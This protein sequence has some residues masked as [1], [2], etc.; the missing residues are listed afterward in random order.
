MRLTLLASAVVMFTVGIVFFEIGQTDTIYLETGLFGFI[1]GGLNLLLAIFTRAGG[2]VQ[3]PLNRQDPVKLFVDK[4]AMGA[5]IYSM[6]FSDNRLVL[7]RLSS[8]RVTVLAALILAIVGLFLAG[9]LGALMGG[10][11]AFSLQ[12]F[13]TQKKRE[14][15]KKGNLLDASGRGDLEIRY[16]DLDKLELTR[17]RVRLYLKDRLV[18]IVISRRY[19]DK[20]RPVLQKLIGSFS[21]SEER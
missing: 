11:T 8:G 5:T 9:L 2:G 12:E 1:L 15:V 18:R 19:S 4:A 17:N 21:A 7:K 14:V 3:I 20:M 6:A 16:G 10:M 13:A